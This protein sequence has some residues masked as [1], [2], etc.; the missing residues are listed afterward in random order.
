MLAVSDH[1]KVLVTLAD[2]SYLDQAKQV[3]SG[4]VH[5]ACWPGDLLLLAYRIPCESSRWFRSRGI[6]VFDCD[7]LFTS[8]TRWR[9]VV[10]SKYY[11]FTPEMKR[12]RH[13]A[14]VECDTLIRAPL[15]GLTSIAGFGAVP[16]PFSPSRAWSDHFRDVRSELA[17]E[18]TAQ[19]KPGLFFNS[20]VMAFD[21]DCITQNTFSEIA[22]L[23]E[24][25]LPLCRLPEQA[26]LN[27]YFR[28]SWIHLASKYNVLRNVLMREFSSD[29]RQDYM[30]S[31]LCNNAV[32][33]H[34]SGKS[35][36]PWSPD[37]PYYQEWLGNLLRAENI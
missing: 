33:L 7:T 34:L 20:G 8:K 25:F 23:T 22:A 30:D 2:E 10:F 13:I 18:L 5:N 36:K 37:N 11:L 26:I 24:K 4:A 21:S 31:I 14:F 19:V 15:E 27:I 17:D 3:F 32:I 6:H 29:L 12:W 16:T 1:S 9:S 28:E 35:L